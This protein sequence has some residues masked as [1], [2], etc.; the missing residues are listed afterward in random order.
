MAIPTAPAGRPVA[1]PRSVSEPLAPM[2]VAG[3]PRW[4]RISDGYR[5]EKANSHRNSKIHTSV[6]MSQAPIEPLPS[7][8]YRNW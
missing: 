4:M 6:A 5:G 7:L 3:R 8:P 2:A 1:G